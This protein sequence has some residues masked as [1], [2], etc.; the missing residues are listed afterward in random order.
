MLTAKIAPSMLSSDF[1]MLAQEAK[2]MEEMGAHYL[3]MDVMD[4][5]FVPNLTLGAPIIKSLRKHTSLFLGIQ[6]ITRLSFNGHQPRAM[7]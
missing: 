2:R 4:G 1:A 6:L 5:H 3:H 7:G